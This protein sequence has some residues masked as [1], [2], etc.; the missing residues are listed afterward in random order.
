MYYV[1]LFISD[2]INLDTICHLVSLA[3]GLSILLISSKNQLLVLLIPCI[4]LF[5]SIWLIS[6]LSLIISYGVFLLGV[7]ASFFSRCAVKLL[8]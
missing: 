7:F 4:V 8:V 5:V 1:S 6:A 2:F 3:K